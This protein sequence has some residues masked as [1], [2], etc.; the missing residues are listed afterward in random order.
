MTPQEYR[1]LTQKPKRSKYGAKQVV[2]NG[3]RFHSTGEFKRWQELMLLK[4]AGKISDLV[5]Q[6]PLPLKAHGVWLP[7]GRLIIDFAYAENNKRIYEDFKG[8]ATPLAKWKIKH[9]EAQY[10]I[11]V[12]ITGHRQSRRRAAG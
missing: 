10:G 8:Y 6:Y 1:A 2:Y 12:L 4:R 7:I 9:A 3:E 11:K 5:R